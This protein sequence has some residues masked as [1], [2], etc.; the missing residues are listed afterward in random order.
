MT[1]ILFS[2]FFFIFFSYPAFSAHSQELIPR[3]PKLSRPKAMPGRLGALHSKSRVF[4]GEQDTS[5]GRLGALH[6][7][8][9]VFNGE[10][11]TSTPSLPNAIQRRGGGL[12]P[13]G[14]LS[15][16]G[17]SSGKVRSTR[18]KKV[19]KVSAQEGSLPRLVGIKT[20]KDLDGAAVVDTLHSM[21]ADFSPASDFSH[22]SD[23]PTDARCETALLSLKKSIRSLGDIANIQDLL[24]SG[25]ILDF[26]NIKDITKSLKSIRSICSDDE[27]LRIASIIQFVCAIC[28]VDRDGCKRECFDSSSRAICRPRRNDRRLPKINEAQKV[29]KLERAQKQDEEMERFWRDFVHLDL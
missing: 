28:L 20:E 1:V 17:D 12:P 25:K 4:N 15:L 13:M 18:I 22:R 3:P 7:K 5:P 19:N 2:F 29:K 8:S 16:P 11:D 23:T 24:K 10:Q 27:L 6:S 26:V 21:T 14:S 9:R